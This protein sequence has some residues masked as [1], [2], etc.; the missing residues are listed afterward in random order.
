MIRYESRRAER[1]AHRAAE[2]LWTLKIKQYHEV[3]KALV[4]ELKQEFTN[5][6]EQGK[7]QNMAFRVQDDLK[8]RKLL[9]IQIF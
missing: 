5:S 4:C 7:C 9:H 6:K 8:Q 3:Q 1:I 2:Q